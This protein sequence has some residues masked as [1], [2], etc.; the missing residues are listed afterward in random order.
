MPPFVLPVLFVTL[1]KHFERL[2][3]NQFYGSSQG[4]NF[5]D[6]AHLDK[7]WISYTIQER[8]A[9]TGRSQLL[10]LR[11]SKKSKIYLF[12]F[13]LPDVLKLKV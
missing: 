2:C 1:F 6:T 8:P 7:P 13:F 9:G 12:S 11:H 4:S 5:R 3:F 10:P